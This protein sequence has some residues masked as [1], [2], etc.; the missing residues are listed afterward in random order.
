MKIQRQWLS[1]LEIENH[2]IAGHNFRRSVVEKT[3]LAELEHQHEVAHDYLVP[4]GH[5]HAS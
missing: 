4:F 2:L 1:K 3:D 5:T